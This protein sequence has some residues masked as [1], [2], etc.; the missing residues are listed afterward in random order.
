MALVF[1]IP[2]FSLI[3][4]GGGHSVVHCALQTLKYGML[5]YKFCLYCKCDYVRKIIS[6]GLGLLVCEVGT[7]ILTLTIYLAGL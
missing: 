6:Y 7:I 1:Y 5:G 3:T 4:R 2:V